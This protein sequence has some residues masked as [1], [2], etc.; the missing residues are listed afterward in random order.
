MHIHPGCA[1]L[2]AYVIWQILAAHHFA[3]PMFMRYPVIAGWHPV[4]W[5]CF[6]LCPCTM[7]CTAL[8]DTVCCAVMHNQCCSFNMYALR[9]TIVQAFSIFLL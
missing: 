9:D 1:H 5:E 7:G 4:F 3:L 2:P 6:D 8:G